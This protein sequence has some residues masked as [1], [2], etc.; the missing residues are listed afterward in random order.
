[1]I[2]N[3]VAFEKPVHSLQA[4][5]RA[6]FGGNHSERKSSQ[7]CSARANQRR[8]LGAQDWKCEGDREEKPQNPHYFLRRGWPPGSLAI[9][10]CDAPRV[11]GYAQNFTGYAALLW[12][13]E[14]A[15][16]HV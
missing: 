4:V 11:C 1:M 10:C 8:R 2:E 16:K 12:K 15:E 5:R 7:R 6:A 9:T 14:S 13:N 3:G